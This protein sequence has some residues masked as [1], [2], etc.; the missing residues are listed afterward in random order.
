MKSLIQ[1]FIKYATSGNVL[2]LLIVVLGLVG[3]AR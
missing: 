1:Y 2:I 3:L